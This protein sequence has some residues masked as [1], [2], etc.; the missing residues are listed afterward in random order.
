MLLELEI[1]FLKLYKIFYYLFNRFPKKKELR[2]LW[3]KATRIKVNYKQQYLC[4]KHFEPQD[5]FWEA[6]RKTRIRYGSIPTI[7]DH[8]RTELRR[9]CDLTVFCI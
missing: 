2:E 7:F 5:V 9:Q 4:S 3:Y 6:G 1:L 8:S